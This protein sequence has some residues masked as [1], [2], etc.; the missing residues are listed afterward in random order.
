MVRTLDG[1]NEWTGK[2]LTW[3][4]VLLTLVVVF[5]VFT[6]YV[7]KNEPIWVF[8]TTTHIYGFHFI[9]LIGY[10]LLY[11]GHV[12]VDVIYRRFSAKKQA[13]LD[14][15]TY[16]CFFF[17]WVG[18]LMW[19]STLMAMASWERMETAFGLFSIPFYP[20]KTAILIGFILIFLQGITTLSRS[21]TVLRSSGKGGEKS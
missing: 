18:V 11:R 2:L 3:V 20:L 7:L 12:A 17:P 8:D 21:V 1:I 16:A 13:I 9:M 5:G 15:F 19:Q 4:V 14:I 10:T 6:R